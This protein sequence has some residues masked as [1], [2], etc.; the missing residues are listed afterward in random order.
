MS[1]SAVNVPTSSPTKEPH[2]H[3]FGTLFHKSVTQG[4]ILVD[5]LFIF[6]ALTVII[7]V[8]VFRRKLWKYLCATTK[9]RKKKVAT[10]SKLPISIPDKNEKRM[11]IPVSLDSSHGASYA[12]YPSY[13][14]NSSPTQSTLPSM[15]PTRILYEDRPSESS[16]YAALASSSGSYAGA[17]SH[18]PAPAAVPLV[19][20]ML[21][22]LQAHPSTN[23]TTVTS[24]ISQTI[25]PPMASGPP[26]MDVDEEE[27]TI[28][29]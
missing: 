1:S 5:V 13:S 2:Y 11:M 18:M 7:T 17:T 24:P 15:N 21:T 9:P 28:T 12:S 10:S 20:E 22:Q 16:S 25:I 27:I 6:L 23:L 26:K 8:A 3:I 29:V 4:D 14:N 19:K